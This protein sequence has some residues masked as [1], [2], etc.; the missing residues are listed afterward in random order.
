MKVRGRG[1]Q[2]ADSRQAIRNELVSN[3]LAMMFPSGVPVSM[4]A[5]SEM[6][7]LYKMMVASSEA[8]V[9][10]RQGVNTFFLTSNG[11][12]I[13]G[14][15]LFLKSGGDTRLQAGAISILTFVGLVLCYAWRSLLSSFGKLNTGKFTVITSLEQKLAAA[16]YAAEWEALGRGT[17]GWVYRS[18]TRREGY[19]PV[20][21]GLIYSVA[22]VLSVLVWSGAWVLRHS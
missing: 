4:E 13:T 10:R 5:H 16:I 1:K 15:S 9:T 11:L 2:R 3:A 20:A 8:L 22:A 7:E 17:I 12:L 14:I 19:V 18:F 21:I 6:F